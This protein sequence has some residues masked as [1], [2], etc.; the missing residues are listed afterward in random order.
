VTMLERPETPTIGPAGMATIGEA[1]TILATVVLI[2]GVA[3]RNAFEA[4]PW[5]T[6][7]ALVGAFASGWAWQ[8]GYRTWR[9]AIGLGASW[10]PL[11]TGAILVVIDLFR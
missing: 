5:A 11:I 9:S 4:A 8:R 2:A 6:L 10:L 1:C 3:T 7:L